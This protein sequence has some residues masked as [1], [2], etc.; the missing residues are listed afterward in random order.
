MFTQ[1][2]KDNFQNNNQIRSTE[3][4]P[5]IEFIDLAKGLCI[6]LVVVYH[7]EV[8]RFDIPGLKALRMPLYFILSGLFFKT[9]GGFAQLTI[10]KVNK[11]LIPFLFFYVLSWMELSA[12]N[13]A[14]W[15]T[16]PVAEPI[17]ALFTRRIGPI[18][19]LECLFLTAVAFCAISVTIR[20]EVAR[21]SIVLIMGAVGYYLSFN[22]IFLPCQIDVVFTAMPFFYFGY[23][24]KK[25]PLLYPSKH[26]CFALPTG[27]L[28][29]AIGSVLYYLC[30]KPFIEFWDNTIK[31]GLILNYLLSVVFVVGVLLICKRIKW[32]PVISYIGRYSII[33]LVMHQIVLQAMKTFEP[34]LLGYG[35]NYIYFLITFGI[36][37]LSIPILRK[38]LPQFTAQKDLIKEDFVSKKLD[39]QKL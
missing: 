14:P 6:F 21:C 20:N 15:N 27:I 24:L 29:L 12:L 8:I 18:W 36:S 37:W 3:S 7:T 39:L 16:K 28:L 2:L 17:Y 32:L 25:T 38:Y 5:R 22:R 23:I 31:G 26:D 19:F 11:I 34:Y 30:D 9:Y 1:F 13:I 4:K 10:K 35:I 33:V